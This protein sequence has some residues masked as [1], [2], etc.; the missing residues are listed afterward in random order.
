MSASDFTILKTPVSKTHY[1]EEKKL[2]RIQLK[3]NHFTSRKFG[4]T[5]GTK[6][7]TYILIKLHMI[8][9]QERDI[10]IHTSSTATQ[11]DQWQMT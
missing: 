5:P 8:N 11:H 6:K 10:S 1:K 3:E 9:M 7:Y 4:T 2:Y